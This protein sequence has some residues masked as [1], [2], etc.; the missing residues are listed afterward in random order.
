MAGF[1]LLTC[2]D[3]V[4]KSVGGSW[5]A[6][7]LAALRFTIA[8]PILSVMLAW[9]Q[10]KTGF[11][12]VHP[13][14]HFWRGF[15][16]AASSLCFFLS[17]FLMPL[18]E[19]TA[20]VFVSP[21]F[22][23]VLS[24]LFLKEPMHPRGWLAIVVGLAGVACVLRPNVLS[25]GLTAFLPLVAAMFFS[26]LMLLNR[27]VAGSASPLAMQWALAAVAAPLLIV[28]AT[29]AHFSGLPQFAVTMPDANV[30]VR[31]AIVAVTASISHWLLY[32]GTLRA[33]AASIAPAIYAQLPAAL[34]IDALIFG[35]FP[36]ILAIAGA[37]LIITAGLIL[38][39]GQGQKGSRLAAD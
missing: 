8:L 1:V 26:M 29:A 37:L 15:A 11:I 9:N 39:K 20:I 3:A 6:P 21:V 7:A 10:G 17:L 27:R 25:L 31:A 32:M 36:D 28:A 18:A 16:I 5:P 12:V 14:L 2:G 33:S 22:T 23:A 38:W 34:I 4:I 35:H 30:V 13:M 19:A 24:A